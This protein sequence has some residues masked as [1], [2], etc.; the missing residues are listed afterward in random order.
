M[1]NFTDV[2]PCSIAIILDEKIEQLNPNERKWVDEAWQK[3]RQW[4]RV[5]DTIQ[6]IY[7]R[8]NQILS[9]VYVYLKKKYMR[10]RKAIIPK[11]RLAVLI[12]VRQ[13]RF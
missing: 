5:R 6:G 9:V 7:W 4:R 8:Q 13:R 1:T 2:K 3:K 12:N 10:W 11:E